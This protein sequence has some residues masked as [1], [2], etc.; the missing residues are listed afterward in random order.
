ME[1]LIGIYKITSPNN[2]IYIGQSIDIERREKNYMRQEFRA[3][4]RLYFSIKK[5]GWNKHTFE[6]LCQCSREK[7]N[8]LEKYYI[9]LYQSFNTLHGMNLDSGGADRIVSEETRKKHSER[10]KGKKPKMAG[11]NKGRKGIYSQLTL[12]KMS[13]AAIKNNPFRNKTHSEETKRKMSLSQTGKKRIVTKK[14]TEERRLMAS[15]RMK[16]FRHTPESKAK[17]SASN[18]KRII[19]NESKKKMSDSRKK[20]FEKLKTKTLGFNR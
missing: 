16:N 11:W 10:L 6:I 14:W 5:H 15:E 20:Y 9:Q 17:I 13:E 18:R 8:D 2:K 12:R 3:Q 4:T 7:L 1:K 19:S